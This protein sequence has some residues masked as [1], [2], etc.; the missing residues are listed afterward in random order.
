MQYL[1]V[2]VKVASL[3]GNAEL[4]VVPQACDA[5]LDLLSVLALVQK[6]V[7]DYILLC[8]ELFGLFGFRIFQESIRVLD[9]LFMF[10]KVSSK[11]SLE[12]VTRSNSYLD[13]MEAVDD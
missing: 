13:A 11:C 5:L 12:L 4:G 2:V 3:K 9:L 1:E 6:A 10:A 7:R 8:Y